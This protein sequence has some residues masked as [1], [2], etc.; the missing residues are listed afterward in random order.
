MKVTEK[1]ELSTRPLRHMA[2]QTTSESDIN[3]ELMQEASNLRGTED[4]RTE[5][6]SQVQQTDTQNKINA[7]VRAAA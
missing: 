2:K 4:G 6:Q 5:P 7:S 1:L 3:L